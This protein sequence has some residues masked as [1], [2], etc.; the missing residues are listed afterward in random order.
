MQVDKKK[1]YILLG[2][3]AVIIVVIVAA[4]QTKK[5]QNSQPVTIPTVTQATSTEEVAPSK[6]A[7]DTATV[8]PEVLKESVAVASGTSL[9]TKDN[10]VV[11]AEGTPVKLNVMPSSNE[12]PK[13]SAPVVEKQIVASA[14]TIKVSVSSAGFVPN[15]FKVKEGQLVNFVLTS[16]DEYTHVFLFDDKSLIAAALGTGN[17]E[18]RVKSWNAPKKGTYTFRCDI[19]GHASRG[20]TGTMIVE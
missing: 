17:F 16:T 6:N 20:E 5:V 13:E 18:T 19:P 11:T 15:S 2:V 1:L 10:K 4:I 7:V 9:I 8:T 12:A 3:I 14:N